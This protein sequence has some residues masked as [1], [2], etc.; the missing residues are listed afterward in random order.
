[1]L[2]YMHPITS[3]DG[4]HAHGP[5]GGH[6][7][8]TNMRDAGRHV[9]SI[10][11]SIFTFNECKKSAQLHFRAIKECHGEG[12]CN[13]GDWW[14]IVDGGKGNVAGMDAELPQGNAFLCTRH[15]GDR[16]KDNCSAGE[17][18]KYHQAVRATTRLKL[19]TVEDTFKEGTTT[20]I[21]KRKGAAKHMKVELFP[22]NAAVRDNTT[23]NWSEGSHAANAPA[24]S[25][26][27]HCGVYE[28]NNAHRERFFS[29]RAKAQSCEGVLPPK[30]TDILEQVT[31]TARKLQGE[32]AM[33]DPENKDRE[34]KILSAS[35][36]RVLISD[37]SGDRQ[38]SDVSCSCGVPAVKGH[39]CGHNVKHAMELG[40]AGSS[41]FHY[42]D[43]TSCWQEQ[44]PEDAEW[45]EISLHTARENGLS[46]PKVRYPPLPAPKVGRP[47]GTKRKRRYDEKEQ[48]A[49]KRKR[50]T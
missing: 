41:L 16:V 5:W 26:P 18:S 50:A 30:V 24:R 46:D 39:P 17:L 32:V 13:T 44:Y 6:H 23:T 47:K 25:V 42:K 40:L 36:T 11:T 15:T 29:N 31:E 7:Y 4:A 49:G 1:M 20:Y 34:G 35:G 38:V 33:P 19:T 9:V 48:P 14:N 22:V 8:D 37:I 45:P 3:S 2:P 12:T 43:T 21:E 10:M 27:M 28:F